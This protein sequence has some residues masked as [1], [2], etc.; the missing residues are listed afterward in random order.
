MEKKLK[1]GMSSLQIWS[2]DKTHMTRF[3]EENGRWLSYLIIW[4][5]NIHRQLQSCH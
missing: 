5:I 3:S 4:L 2:R 1:E